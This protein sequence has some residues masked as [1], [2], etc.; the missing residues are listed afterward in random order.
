MF[1][2]RGV[3]GAATPGQM[4]LSR[5]VLGTATAGQMLSHAEF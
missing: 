2:S 1:L 4:L 5:G 3:L